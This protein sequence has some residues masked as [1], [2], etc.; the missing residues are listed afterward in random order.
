[1]TDRRL[2]AAIGLL[3]GIGAVILFVFVFSDDTVDAPA[4]DEPAAIETT[5][6]TTT[7]TTEKAPVT[8]IEI[9]GG[10]PKGGVEELEVNKGDQVKFKVVS[11]AASEVHVHGYDLFENVEAGGSVSFSFVAE[12][13]GIFDVELEDTATQIAELRVNP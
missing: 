3:L 10:E 7:T 4:V 9:V 2:G 5:T 6:S 8:T 1:V 11:D 13:D 12:I